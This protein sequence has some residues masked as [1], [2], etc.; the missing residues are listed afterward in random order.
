M[1]VLS[2]PFYLK[3]SHAVGN[4]HLSVIYTTKSIPGCGNNYQTLQQQQL[5]S[6][7]GVLDRNNVLRNM[8]FERIA[9]RGPEIYSLAQFFREM[10]QDLIEFF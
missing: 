8:S 2:R 3:Y 9:L 6:R 4:I 5:Q 7:Q 1:Y 10:G